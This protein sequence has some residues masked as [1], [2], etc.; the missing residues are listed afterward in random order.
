M[1]VL[2]IKILCS[3]IMTGVIWVIQL[4][5]YPSFRYIDKDHWEAFYEQH[6]KGITLIVLPVMTLELITTII[7]FYQDFYWLSFGSLLL[8]MIIWLSTFFIQVPL[9]NGIRSNR[10]SITICELVKTNW[11]RTLAWSVNTIILLIGYTLN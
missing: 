10:D 4:V 11:I 1:S 8:V 2:T 9:H 6:M 5:H 7:Y 3:A